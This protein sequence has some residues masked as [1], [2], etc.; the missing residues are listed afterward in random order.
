[1]MRT[2]G[3]K[4]GVR[5]ELNPMG[6]GNILK[7]HLKALTKAF[8][9]RIICREAEIA[10]ATGESLA[11]VGP[12]G[13]GKSTIVKMIAGLMRPDEGTIAHRLGDK[14]APQAEWHRHIGL[15]S[16]ELSLYEELSG[17][18]N[19]EFGNRVGGWGKTS[20]ECE[21]VL[22]EVGLGGRGGDLVATY[23]SGM[24][25][26]LKYAAAFL[27]DP[28]LLLLDEPTANLD[29]EGTALIWRA[30]EKRNV[31]LVIA[32]NIPGEAER[33]QSR[34]VAGQ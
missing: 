17:L 11:I 5:R 9:P 20:A 18:E 21:S 6:N 15:V 2:P 34:F 32:T 27:K 16:P 7:L 10:L 22:D 31:A 23:S 4:C 19:L 1:M 12:N 29:E 25:Q 30:V 13:S 3:V 26:R 8:G 14:V 33:A 24:K 28:A